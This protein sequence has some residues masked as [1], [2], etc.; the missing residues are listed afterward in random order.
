MPIYP[1]P[2]ERDW[3]EATHERFAYRCLP[4]VIANQA[5]WWIANPTAFTV[6][7]NGGRR[8]QDLRI[9]YSGGRRDGRIISHFGHGILT[10]AIPY[11]FRTPPGINLWIKGPSNRLKDGIQPLEGIVEADWSAAT[12]TMNWKLTRPNHPVRFA[13]GEPICMITPAPRGLLEKLEPVRT[14]L[15]NNREL[16]A[17]YRVWSRSRDRFNRALEQLNSEAVRRGWQRHYF[18]GLGPEGERFAGHQTRLRLKE[19]VH[20]RSP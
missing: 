18:L 1:A 12:F 3:M 15:K 5:G 6:R 13:V 4:L 16:A 17:G 19:F 20:E 11:L 7:W 8:L 14:P 9:W 2:C 10:F